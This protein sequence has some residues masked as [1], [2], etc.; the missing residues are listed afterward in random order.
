MAVLGSC[1]DIKKISWIWILCQI[2]L[3]RELRI[4]FVGLVLEKLFTLISLVVVWDFT[5]FWQ[6]DIIFHLMLDNHA[7][8]K[9]VM[10]I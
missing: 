1:V 3:T 2:S 6:F 10:S 5:S 4:R 9:Q 7:S 8:V